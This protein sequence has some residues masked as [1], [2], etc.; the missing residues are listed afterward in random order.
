MRGIILRNKAAIFKYLVLNKNNKSAIFFNYFVIA[1]FRN[2]LYHRTQK[3]RQ[4]IQ[5]ANMNRFGWST[6]LF[7]VW[8]WGLKA[9][10]IVDVLGFN[11]DDG[12]RPISDNYATFED[13]AGHKDTATING[14][15][16]CLRLSMHMLFKQWFFSFNGK[17]NEKFT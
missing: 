13:F 11:V 4:Q 1:F 9:E 12:E 14:L 8:I 3:Y 17:S 5:S 15:T 16:V 7:L 6:I 10:N 2:L